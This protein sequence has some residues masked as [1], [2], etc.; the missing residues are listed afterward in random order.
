MVR[1]CFAKKDATLNTA[2]EK[3]AKL[4]L[5]VEYFDCRGDMSEINEL[6][7]TLHFR[8][9]EHITNQT[10]ANS[11]NSFVNYVEQNKEPFPRFDRIADFTLKLNQVAP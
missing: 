10:I 3:L 6:I 5:C 11:L 7:R 9:I 8:S 1:F 4:N 2:L